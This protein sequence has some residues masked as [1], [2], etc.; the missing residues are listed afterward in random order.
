MER[1]VNHLTRLVGDLLDVSSVL[2]DK[3][4][5][6]QQRLDLGMLAHTTAED[7]RALL[8]KVKL[9][10]QL[11]VPDKPVW[12]MGDATRLS[13]ILTNLLDNCQKFADGG[14]RITVRVTA[15]EA[16]KQ[17]ILFVRDEGM[18]I[19]PELLPHLFDAFKQADRSLDRR[20]GG[21]GLGLTLVKGL[22]ELHGGSVKAYSAGPGQG[23]EFTV[24]LPLELEPTPLVETKQT[25]EP[26]KKHMRI[27]VIE[28]QPDGAEM[29]RMLLCHLGHK[30]KVA[31]T[32]C[33]GVEV[34]QEWQ[35]DFVLC[36]IGLPGMDG[37][38]VARAI[39]SQPHLD[40]VRLLAVTGYGSD[41]DLQ[42]SRDAG[43]DAHLVKP[44]DPVELQR[45]LTSA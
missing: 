35:P 18:G 39:R 17:A 44:V 19:E 10:L 37:W 23:A 20:R 27:L 24:R 4:E 5:L 40:R 22:T 33:K 11:E 15:D 12:V 32:G 2:H 25:L 30:V 41:E 1:Q 7:R 14:G 34:A 36:D 28:D 13:Q 29:L 16:H 6:R 8:E 43:F 42:R 9:Q 21:L 38:G 45:L 3:I 26:T 31:H